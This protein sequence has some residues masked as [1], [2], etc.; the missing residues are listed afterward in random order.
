METVPIFTRLDEP[1]VYDNRIETTELDEISCDRTLI[2]NLNQA[3]TNFKFFYPG[4]FPNLLSSSDSGFLVKCRFRTLDNNA[5]N[6][7][8]NITLSSNW[9]GYLFENVQ[10]CLG[11]QVIEHIN[12]PAIVM[13]I[14][15]N[16][17]SD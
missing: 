5:T 8:S 10:L 15:Y 1:I 16:M 4:D 9:F 12:N 17:E 14:V 13:D 3:N 6:M 2:N 7:N 11:G